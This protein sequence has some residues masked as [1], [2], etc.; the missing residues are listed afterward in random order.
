MGGKLFARTVV[1]AAAASVAGGWLACDRCEREACEAARRPYRGQA[2]AQGISGVVSS[3]SDSGS[4]GCFPCAWGEARLDV[5]AT[6][7]PVGN[8]AEAEAVV[9]AGPA[10][11]T[12]LARQRYQQPLGP[13]SYLA[14]VLPGSCAAFSLAAGEVVSMNVRT[15][16]GP[17]QLVLF[18]P[19]GADPSDRVFRIASQAPLVTVQLDGGAYLAGGTP[20]RISVLEP[21][22]GGRGGLQFELGVA[23]GTRQLNLSVSQAEVW[24]PRERFDVGF[25]RDNQNQINDGDG[26]ARAV[27]RSGELQL[28]VSADGRFSGSFDVTMEQLLPGQS[29]GQGTFGPLRG[30]I[31]GSWTFSC[32]TAAGAQSWTSDPNLRSAFCA[33]VARRAGLAR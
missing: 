1:V 31:A 2:L 28:V 12:I 17:T 25:S 6:P 23:R 19:A 26:D 14:C 33:D 8:A 4:N 18:P 30:T 24:P 27:S 13:G 9:A 11:T 29:L 20:A 22:P 16:Y 3:E 10:R 32:S 5:W 15:L 7:T 21:V